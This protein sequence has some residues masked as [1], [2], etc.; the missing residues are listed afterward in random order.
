TFL[1][2]A[3]TNTLVAEQTLS[4][5]LACP[6]QWFFGPPPEECPEEDAQQTLIIEQQF[7]SGRMIYIGNT[8]TVYVLFN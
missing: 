6:V 8:N 1:I 5:P 4:I 3:S 2:S 7:Q